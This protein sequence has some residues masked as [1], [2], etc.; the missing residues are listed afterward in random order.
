MDEYIQK[1][2]TLHFMNDFSKKTHLYKVFAIF[3]FCFH[4]YFECN[5]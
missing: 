4:K 1:L 5:N 3:F 2:L